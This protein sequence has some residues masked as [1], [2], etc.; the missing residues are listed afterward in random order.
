M[1]LVTDPRTGQTTDIAGIDQA[2]LDDYIARNGNLPGDRSVAEVFQKT[3]SEDGGRGGDA[4]TDYNGALD[5]GWINV[6]IAGLGRHVLQTTDAA[7]YLATAASSND[8]TGPQY[9]AD[10]FQ[11]LVD[12]I[13]GGLVLTTAPSGAPVLTRP[14]GTVTQP[15]GSGTY[16]T[17][18]TTGSTAPGS[19]G[20]IAAAAAGQPL[21]AIAQ[22]LPP[23]AA[24]SPAALIAI[25][26]VLLKMLGIF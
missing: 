22:Q 2:T 13:S 14:A 26:A 19:A 15:G 20:S 25:G 5:T 17:Y 1:G 23:S 12:A 24:S 21:S 8:P 10:Q 4:D 16:Q 18:S 11:P 3:A 9:T 7:A 6:P